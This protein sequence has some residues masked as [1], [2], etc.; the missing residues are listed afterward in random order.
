MPRRRR[1]AVTAFDAASFALAV[2]QVV[3]HRLGRMAAAGAQPS[4]ADRKEFA[5]MVSEKGAAFHE[6][7][8]EMALAATRAQQALAWSWLGAMAPGA[9]PMAG[10][11]ALA[12][13][14]GAWQ[15]AAM[16]VLASGFHPVRRRAVANA[17]RLSRPSRSKG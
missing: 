6:S 7:W 10:N 17:K 11:R 2:P 3:A 14:A 5:R 12:H 9:S 13:A 15:S 1:S 16:G 8:A 4:A